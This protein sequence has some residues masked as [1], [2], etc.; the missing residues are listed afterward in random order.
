MSVSTDLNA[1][2]SK[3]TSAAEK[4][5]RLPDKVKQQREPVAKQMD[6]TQQELLDFLNQA[7]SECLQ[8]PNSMYLRME[9]KQK[10]LP[11]TPD[12]LKTIIDTSF[13]LAKLEPYYD[14]LLANWRPKKKRRGASAAATAEHP[15]I[16]VAEVVLLALKKQLQEDLCEYRHS[17]K[18]SKTK[19]RGYK[20]PEESI[21]IPEPVQQKA[22]TLI[23]LELKL[24]ELRDEATDIKRKYQEQKESVLPIIEQGLKP[25]ERQ[26]VEVKGSNGVVKTYVMTAVATKNKQAAP[27]KKRGSS[28]SGA[29]AGPKINA[30][31]FVEALD[32]VCAA[33]ERWRAVNFPEAKQQLWKTDADLQK[34]VYSFLCEHLKNLAEARAKEL[35]AKRKEEQEAGPAEGGPGGAEDSAVSIKMRLKTR[36]EEDDL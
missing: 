9:T 25:E 33:Q 27:G 31:Q 5:K 7:N 26:E 10:Y 2:I 21:A 32:D 24:K 22:A 17:V 35:Q 34:D 19:K 3:Y 20:A 18:V 30:K 13:S 11:V 28:S 16:P 15:F 14:E 36:N 23:Q 8:L 12:E 4:L 29:Q 1:A 6:A